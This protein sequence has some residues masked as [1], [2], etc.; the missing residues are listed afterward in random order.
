MENMEKIEKI[1][2]IE[3]I[4]AFIWS[5]AQFLVVLIG[6]IFQKRIIYE[7]EIFECHGFLLCGILKYLYHR[8]NN[9]EN[10]HDETGEGTGKD[11]Y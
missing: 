6:I 11:D 8:D 3:D 1:E 4:G 2:K 9:T 7:K 10:T 5:T